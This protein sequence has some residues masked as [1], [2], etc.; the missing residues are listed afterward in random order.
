MFYCLCIGSCNG[1]L[2]VD[3]EY[4]TDTYVMVRCRH[5]GTLTKHWK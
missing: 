2:D 1:S 4:E 5:C 3:I